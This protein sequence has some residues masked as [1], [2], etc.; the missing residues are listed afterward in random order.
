M[1]KSLIT[2][3]QDVFKFLGR[4]VGTYLVLTLAYNGYLWASKAGAFVPDL[5]TH[6]VAKQSEQIINQ[7]GYVA[8]VAPSADQP[9]L[10][11]FV[12][13]AYVA[14]VIEGCNALSIIILFIAFVAAFNGGLKRTLVY[15]LAGAVLIYAVNLIRI[16]ILAIALYTYPEHEPLL[17]DVIFP[18]II[19]GMVFLL[20][21]IWVKKLPKTTT[22]D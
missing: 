9:M 4:F 12:N 6:L 5:V 21:M 19:Y 8:A 17:H 22:H 13:G 14:R 10:M 16:A 18:G 2:Q 20:W 1:L 3:Y 7:F 15:I 11:L